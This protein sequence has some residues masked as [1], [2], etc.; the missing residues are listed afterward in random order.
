M[1]KLAL[2][3]AKGFDTQ[4]ILSVR[5]QNVLVPNYCIRVC[6]ITIVQLCSFSFIYFTCSFVIPLD[7]LKPSEHQQ[8]MILCNL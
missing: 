7:N 1:Y 3:A 6:T 8:G 5:I 4:I 2:Y